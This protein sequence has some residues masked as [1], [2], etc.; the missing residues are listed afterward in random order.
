[1]LSKLRFTEGNAV[2]DQIVRLRGIF[3]HRPFPGFRKRPSAKKN[4]LVDNETIIK[5]KK[6]HVVKIKF[7]QQDTIIAHKS[8]YHIHR[9]LQNNKY[10]FNQV[11]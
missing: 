4:S 1:M 3:C 9:V 2:I 5:S 6:V 11:T 8:L 10:I 7:Y